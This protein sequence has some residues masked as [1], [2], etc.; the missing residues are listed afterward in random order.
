MLRMTGSA[1][2]NLRESHNLPPSKVLKLLQT[3]FDEEHY[4]LHYKLLK[5]YVNLGLVVRK[6]HRVL[7]FTQNNWLTP[8]ITL[9]SEKRQT[10][11]NKFEES[12]YKL[13]NNVVYGKNSESKRRRMKI[14]LTKDARRTLTIVSKFEFDKFKVFGEN[15]AALT[16]RPRKIHWDAPTIVGATILDLPKY[17]MYQF[18]YETCDLHSTVDYSIVILIACYTGS[19]VKISTVNWRRAMFLISLTSQITQQITNCTAKKINA[20]S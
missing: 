15:M 2:V 20:S 9:N 5:L 12:F 17:Y 10:A 18:H 3:F 1:T 14:E 6:M 4:V 19:F 7:Q 16:S 13:M 8:Y 11:S